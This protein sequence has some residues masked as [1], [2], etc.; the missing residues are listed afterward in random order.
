GGQLTIEAHGT[1]WPQKVKVSGGFNVLNG[2]A[3][4]TLMGLD[5]TDSISNVVSV[6]NHSGL[7]RITDCRMVDHYNQ[8]HPESGLSNPFGI[9]ASNAKV[10]MHSC[11]ISNVLVAMRAIS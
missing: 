1:E 8:T 2:T 10:Y 6:S 5:I 4:I 11:E 7:V 3:P 9:E